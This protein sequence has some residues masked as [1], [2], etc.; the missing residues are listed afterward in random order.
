MNKSEVCFYYTMGAGALNYS[1]QYS[2]NMSWQEA[3]KELSYF[4]AKGS[5][6]IKCPRQNLNLGSM[7]AKPI[8]FNCYAHG[9]WA[10]VVWA[11]VAGKQNVVNNGKQ[12]L[13]FSVSREDF[14]EAESPRGAAG[15][16]MLSNMPLPRAPGTIKVGYKSNVVLQRREKCFSSHR[17][18]RA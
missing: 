7:T 18:S 2:S 1:G 8:T 10:Q 16:F 17:S 3:S 12:N 15:S 14:L 11:Q 9:L 13:G 4:F 5:M 6:A